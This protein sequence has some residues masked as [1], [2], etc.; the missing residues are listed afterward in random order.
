MSSTWGTAWMPADQPDG[1][2]GGG[3]KTTEF[4]ENQL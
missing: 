2:G 4:P 3:R 1:G